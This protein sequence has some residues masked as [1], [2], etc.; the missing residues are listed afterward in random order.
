MNRIELFYDIVSPYSWFAFETLCRY[1][2]RWSIDLVLR[3]FFLNAVMRATDNKPAGAFPAKLPYVQTDLVRNARYFDVPLMPPSD[4]VSLDTRRPM[5]LLALVCS[6]S[7][8]HLEQLTRSLWQ[9]HWRDGE[10]T[11][12][13]SVLREALKEAAL[14]ADSHDRLI[15]NVDDPATKQLLR[16]TT[17]EAIARGTFGS[18]SL[19]LQ[20]RDAEEM[21]FGSDRFPLIAQHLGA[22]LEGPTSKNA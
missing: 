13:D 7:P 4:S 5:R 14:P 12:A 16:D 20:G 10:N 1:R 11:S 9:L 22:S 17:D 15:G 21:F 8:G 2:E 18:P 6:E 19:F 3:P